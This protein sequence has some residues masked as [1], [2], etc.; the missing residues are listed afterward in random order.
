MKHQ[1]ILATSGTRRRDQMARLEKDPKIR[2][3]NI[4]PQVG[5]IRL[6]DDI[7]Y[8]VVQASAE[9]WQRGPGTRRS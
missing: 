7:P 9:T 8:R 3:I 4:K 1:A 5:R 2:R 6:R